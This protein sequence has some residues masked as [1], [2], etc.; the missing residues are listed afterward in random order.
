MLLDHH[1]DVHA[2]SDGDRGRSAVM[3][4]V[5][6]GHLATV[7]LLLQA[8]ADPSDRC[9]P[10]EG[11]YLLQQQRQ[12]AQWVDRRSRIHRIMSLNSRC[13]TCLPR[14]LIVHGPLR[15]ARLVKKQSRTPRV[16]VS[17]PWCGFVVSHA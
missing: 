9:A 16:L 3:C 14:Q 6:G 2:K 10:C 1:A 4:A 17:I 12:K 7:H 5:A 8:R 11:A 15:M 13:G